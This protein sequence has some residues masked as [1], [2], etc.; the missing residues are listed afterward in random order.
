M[1][2]LEKI[3]TALSA[4]RLPYALVGG[5]AVAL[6]GAVRGTVDIDFVVE[7]KLETLAHIEELFKQHSLVSRLPITAEDVFNFREEYIKN[8]NLIAWNFYNPSDV[9]EQVDIIINYDL[10]I[11]DVIEFETPR[12]LIMV[13][14]VPRLLDMKRA[15]GRP[16]D[17]ED[18]A[19]LEK[20]LAQK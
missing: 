12:T 1:S 13:L 17:L 5:H 14:N 8:R 19:A 10:N 6:H 3:C 15:S 16:Q 20:V 18:V 7:W 11:K 4:A 2:F 9:T